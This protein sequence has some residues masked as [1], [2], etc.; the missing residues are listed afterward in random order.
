M[1]VRKPTFFLKKPNPMDFELQLTT[2]QLERRR[3][4]AGGVL[5]ATYVKLFF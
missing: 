2:L 3:V 4:R 1:C 5:D